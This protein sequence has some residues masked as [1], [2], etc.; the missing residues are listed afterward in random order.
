MRR[1]EF[2]GNPEIKEELGA[3]KY[4]RFLGGAGYGKTA[5]LAML[6]DGCLRAVGYLEG[7]PYYWNDVTECCLRFCKKSARWTFWN[8]AHG[9][10]PVADAS[11]D[12]GITPPAV[13]G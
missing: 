5:Q 8:A 10:F 1:A 13:G 12:D 11:G 7:R 2:W 6:T 9:G 4:W 3:V